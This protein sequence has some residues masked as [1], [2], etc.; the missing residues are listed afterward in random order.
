MLAEQCGTLT[1]CPSGGVGEGEFAEPVTG[2]V[3]LGPGIGG[4]A[5]AVD[6]F[7]DAGEIGFGEKTGL[8]GEG[9][10]AKEREKKGSM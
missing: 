10:A 6:G 2:Q 1:E 5:L 8:G 3:G 9:V 7:V 4:P